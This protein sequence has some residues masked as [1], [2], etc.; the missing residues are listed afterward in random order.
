MSKHQNTRLRNNFIGTKMFF[1]ELFKELGSSKELKFHKNLVI[2][3]ENRYGR[4]IYI[5]GLLVL[6]LD[7]NNFRFKSTL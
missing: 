7:C 5:S 1:R 2:Y 4:L 3:F 6:L